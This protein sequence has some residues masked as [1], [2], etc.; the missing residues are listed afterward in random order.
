M[1]SRTQCFIFVLG[2]S[3]HEGEETFLLDAL[4]ELPETTRLIIAPRHLSRAHEIETLIQ[5]AGYSYIKRST[6]QT[7]RPDTRIIL[8]D[9]FGEMDL[10]YASADAVFLGGGLPAHV[11]G[12]SPL[13]PLR[14]G[15]AI[16][17]GPYTE[18]FADI[19]AELAPRGWSNIVKTPSEFAHF[20]Q[21]EKAIS[22]SD[23]DAYFAARKGALQ[24]TLATLSSLLNEA[25]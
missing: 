17:T 18:N 19:H 10:W 4:K 1:A 24:H 8:A 6:G 20:A 13:E 7:T 15:L 9:T 14:F 3:T 5:T 21:S 16:A 12:H 2:A 25:D 11:G 23:I 22:Q